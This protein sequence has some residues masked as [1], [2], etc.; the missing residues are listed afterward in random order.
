ME[1]LVWVRIRNVVSGKACLLRVTLWFQAQSVTRA[2]FRLR[3][4]IYM[5]EFMSGAAEILHDVYRQVDTCC[6]GTLNRS[7]TVNLCNG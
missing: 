5:R 2:A 3:L 1:S 4:L 7:K 6:V